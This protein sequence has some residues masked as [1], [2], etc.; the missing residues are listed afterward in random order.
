MKTTLL[1]LIC[2]FSFLQVKGQTAVQ[3]VVQA[4]RAFAQMALDQD[5]RAAFLQHMNEASLLAGKGK[6]VKGRDLYLNLP[7]DTVGKLHWEPTFA[8]VSVS[9]ELGYTSGPFTYKVKGKAVAFGHFA[10]VWLRQSDGQWKFVIDL[11]GPH[12]PHS[13]AVK[14]DTLLY[15]LPDKTA[16]TQQKTTNLLAH[17]AAFSKAAAGSLAAYSK[18]LHPEARLFRAN[19]LPS[20]TAAQRD[21][22][23]KET[24]HLSFR[25]EGSQIAASGDLGV[26]YGLCELR[27]RKDGK[28]IKQAG[29]YMRVWRKDEVKGWQILHE[30]LIAELVK[31]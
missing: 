25:P 6:L 5:T 15:V 3:Q 13:T 4:E 19:R 14:D 24:T 1:F 21:D 28:E 23:L 29:P 22:L 2:L 20:V 17:D 30:S 7:P 9:G 26:V 16:K 11:G 8:T 12:G 31:E 10:T 27:L 18:V